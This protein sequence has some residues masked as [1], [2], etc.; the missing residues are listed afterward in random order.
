MA[1]FTQRMI[2]AATL[3]VPTYEEVEHDTTATGQAAGVVGIV[4]V[5]SAIGA[6]GAGGAEMAG[7]V[8]S[9]FVGW[10]IWSAVT[11]VIGTKV[12]DGT[13][14]M[15]EMLRTLGFAQAPG[16]LNVLGFI[17]V[18]GWIVRLAVG[19]W[20]LVCG[21]IAVRQALDFTTGKAIGTVLLGWLCYFVV[22]ALIAGLFGGLGMFS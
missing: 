13:A 7:G 14:D 9:A 10:L 20:M 8:V 22:A 2:G 17:P 5:A 12:F 1:S 21:V 15:G 3:D 18:L 11:L 4:A 19:I 16:V 6:I